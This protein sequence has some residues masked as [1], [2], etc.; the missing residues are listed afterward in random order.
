MYVYESSV[1]I[2]I[3]KIIK[4]WYLIVIKIKINLIY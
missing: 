2:K 1:V 3:E 4:N